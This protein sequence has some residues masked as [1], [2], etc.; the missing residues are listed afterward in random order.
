MKILKDFLDMESTLW[1]ENK[2]TRMKFKFAGGTLD[3]Y[4]IR[5]KNGGALCPFGNEWEYFPEEDIC[6][7]E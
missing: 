6:P 4:G 5:L 3:L 2:F 1:K 7:F